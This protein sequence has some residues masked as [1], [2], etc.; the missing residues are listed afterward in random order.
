M[1]KCEKFGRTNQ[2][3]KNI[4]FACRITN[5]RTHV[6]IH[7]H[8][9]ARTHIHNTFYLLFFYCNNGYANAPKCY[10]HRLPCFAIALTDC[11]LQWRCHVLTMSEE[12]NYITI[13]GW[14]TGFFLA[15]SQEVICWSLRW[16]LGFKVWPILVGFG[17]DKGALEQGFLQVLWFPS[18]SNI[19]PFP[20]SSSKLLAKERK[21]VGASGTSNKI[22]RLFKF[23]EPQERNLLPLVYFLK[24]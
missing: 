21:A 14:T 5:V 7:T 2:A 18:A 13:W 1:R 17:A 23:V 20:S 24:L 6:Q 9:H 10:V 19:P 8:T 4:K 15:R 3:T 12:A 11:C 22:G 16:W